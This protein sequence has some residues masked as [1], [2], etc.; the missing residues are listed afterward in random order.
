MKQHFEEENNKIPVVIT[1][2]TKSDIF[3]TKIPKIIIITGK[4]RM[5]TVKSLMTRTRKDF[6]G[7]FLP[8]WVR[9]SKRL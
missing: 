4:L 2:L 8:L 3:R 9:P 7:R 1:I 6:Y 5:N